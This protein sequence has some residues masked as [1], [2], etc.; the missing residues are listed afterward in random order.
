MY[1][2]KNF[3]LFTSRPYVGGCEVN[4]LVISFI[5]FVF[6]V[7][8]FLF[9]EETKCVNLHAQQNTDKVTIP[10]PCIWW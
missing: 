8:A 5:Y 9:K 2:A 7:Y 4:N 3:L 1:A 6:S 10:F